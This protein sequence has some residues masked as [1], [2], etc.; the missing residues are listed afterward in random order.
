MIVRRVEPS[1]SSDFISTCV[2][3]FL[4][5]GRSRVLLSVLAR[6]ALVREDT[7]VYFALI[8]GV[9]AGAAG[10]S[11]LE[12]AQG[13]VA[14][15]YIDS[16]LPTFQRRGVHGALIRARL[17]EAKLAGCSHAMLSAREGT[18][19]ARNAVR[20]GLERVYAKTQMIQNT[21]KESL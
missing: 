3:G 12:T 8:N 4:P 15:L 9:I 14:Q 6:L 20:A 10:M 16:T 1:E 5:N 13:K 17:N 2:E 21:Q 18:G 11:I 7:T 19:S